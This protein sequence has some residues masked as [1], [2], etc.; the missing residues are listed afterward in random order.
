MLKLFFWFLMPLTLWM[1]EPGVTADPDP[2][3]VLP[4]STANPVDPPVTEPAKKEGEQ[5][6]FTQDQLDGIIA[7]RA[8][9]ASS[10]ATADLLEELGVEDIKAAKTLLSEAATARQAQMTELEK[11]QEEIKQAK[12]A[13]TQAEA[14]AQE[15]EALAN[16][17]LMQSAVIAEASKP[18]HKIKPEAIGDLWAFVDKSKLEVT[19]EGTVKGAEE[20]IKTALKDRPYM[21]AD[22]TPSPGTTN[23]QK[24]TAMQQKAVTDKQPIE[25]Q[26]PLVNF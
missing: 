10:K 15:R 23:R 13:Q 12:D 26:R 11:A 19:E 22:E 20:V 5:V 1:A 7:G 3:L 25:E 17:R 2:D 16:E 21:I 9:Q 14:A 24:R 8:K 18:D 4:T 6:T